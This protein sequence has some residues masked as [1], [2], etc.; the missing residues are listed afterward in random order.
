[1]SPNLTSGRAGHCPR[2]TRLGSCTVQSPDP[3]EAPVHSPSPPMGPSSSLLLAFGSVRCIRFVLCSHLP[4]G[5]RGSPVGQVQACLGPVCTSNLPQ[6]Q[7]RKCSQ[8]TCSEFS[9]L[10]VP[11]IFPG[12]I[13]PVVSR[14]GLIFPFLSLVD[15][16]TGPRNHQMLGLQAYKYK[17]WLDHTILILPSRTCRFKRP[18]K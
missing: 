7:V 5:V 17:G 15:S 8:A 2:A 3:L 11:L 18:P 14:G 9:P 12:L 6:L 4:G 10:T 1:M 13:F 16:G